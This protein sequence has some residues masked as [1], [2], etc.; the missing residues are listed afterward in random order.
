MGAKTQQVGGGPSV[1]LANDFVKFLQGGLSGSGQFGAAQ[2]QQ[3]QFGKNTPGTLLSKVRGFLGPNLPGQNPGG[4]T[5]YQQPFGDA[6]FPGGIGIPSGPTSMPSIPGG[7]NPNAATNG[8]LGNT[9]LNQNGPTQNASTG[10]GGALNKFIGGNFGDPTY[11]V[12]TSGLE[13]LAGAGKYDFGNFNPSTVDY[14]GFNTN[15]L[16]NFNASQGPAGLQG[17]GSNPQL[18]DMISRLGSVGGN[19]ADFQKTWGIGPGGIPGYDKAAIGLGSPDLSAYTG[20]LDRQK[21][22]NVADIRARF[23]AQGGTAFGTPAAFAEGNYLAAADAENAAKLADIGRAQQGLQLQADLGGAG[24][25]AQNYGNYISNLTSGG[26]TGANL[27]G[28]GANALGN[29]GSLLTG[30]L[31]QDQSGILGARG[32]DIQSQGLNLDAIS[33]ATGLNLD[34]LNAMS[35][36]G[37][38]VGQLFNQFQGNAA[39]NQLGAAGLD[40][41]ALSRALGFNL[42]GQ[43][44]NQQQGQFNT[45]QQGNMINQIMQAFQNMSLPGIPQAQMIQKPSTFQNIMGTVGGLAGA[46]AP[47]FGPGAIFG[48]AV[49]SAT[50][51]R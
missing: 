51:G 50:G 19:A 49:A 35:S 47:F 27:V 28:T 31:G 7:G 37:I 13:G 12:D 20:I 26:Q 29:A 46:A 11:G 18:Q 33:R 17:I 16:S 34:Q 39:N 10:F 9:G 42:Q 41:D 23:G 14:S 6:S 5:G 3:Q 40:M 45:S 30:A 8:L 36:Q 15:A 25:N 32:Q 48:K 1:G 21:G 38:N 43:G 4:S 22:Q 24:I 44:M 2:P